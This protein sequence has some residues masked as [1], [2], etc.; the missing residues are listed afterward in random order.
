M[1]IGYIDGTRGLHSPELPP[2]PPPP[3]KENPWSAPQ[4]DRTPIK[5]FAHSVI[6]M[7]SQKRQIPVAVWLSMPSISQGKTISYD[8]NSVFGLFTIHCI[9]T[10]QYYDTTIA[11]HS[12]RAF[13]LS[14]FLYLHNNLIVFNITVV[15]VVVFNISNLWAKCPS[16]PADVIQKKKLRGF[17]F[18]YRRRNLFH[19]GS[20]YWWVK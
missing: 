6:L 5:A 13:S 4:I 16:P 12:Q 10:S 3:P 15:I 14:P 11:Y 8:L 2:P 7:V 19:T 17:N 9:M 1:S 18:I 20:W